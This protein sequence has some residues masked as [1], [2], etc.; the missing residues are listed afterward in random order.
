[1]TAERG[2]LRIDHH[3]QL[4]APER[5][6]VSFEFE[7]RPMAGYAGEPLAVA[8]HAAGVR[9]LSRSFK[10]HRPRGIG[11]TCLTPSCPNCQMTVDGMYGVPACETP[12]RGGE[13]VR[14]ERAWPNADHDLLAVLDRL[15]VA[16]P[17]GFQ[18]RHFS[19]HPRLAQAAER[20]M[21]LVAGGG[22]VPDPQVARGWVRPGL[23][24]HRVDLLVVGGGP[25][26][27]AGALT[28]AEAGLRVA[29]VERDQELGGW[30]RAE[31][32]TMSDSVGTSAAAWKL[33]AA[34]AAR[35]RRHPRIEAWTGAT[36][37]GWYE[38]NVLPVMIPS[39]VAT[40]QPDSLLIATGSYEC[41]LPFPGSDL[42]G[43]MLA[44]AAQRLVNLAHVRPGR[45]ALVVTDE[46]YGYAVAAQLRDVGVRVAAVADP[47]P[48][49]EIFADETA[50]SLSRGG[51]RVLPGHVPGSV[52]GRAGVRALRIR[53]PAGGGR[54]IACDT[55]VVATGRRPADELLSQ[56]AYHGAT[57]LEVADDVVAEGH[58][59]ASPVLPGVYV[60]GG[61]T[62]CAELS[63]AM[64]EGA[65]AGTAIA[66]EAASACG[67]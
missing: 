56:R 24:H 57:L 1:M 41:L 4:P 15:A 8:L 43:V 12:L 9:V 50:W 5:A 22:R 35:V 27:L 13:A 28:A 39:G 2:R 31:T 32:G 7:G 33:A 54:T 38:T 26:G 34:L 29:V 16:L 11:L 6:E 10:Y 36:V 18:F 37:L 3:P 46:S 55:V 19:H 17:A 53:R 49:E 59:A 14:R 67:S 47:R 23:G 63:A 52:L 60:A 25:A 40:F 66:K 20:I 61:I 51:V 42:P 30:L 58:Q 64:A 65:A 48:A 62:G 21:S 44:A 45:Q